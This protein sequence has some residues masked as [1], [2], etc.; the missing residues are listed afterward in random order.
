MLLG[1]LTI[2]ANA[3][4]P[5]PG[6]QQNQGPGPGP[7]GPPEQYRASDGSVWINTDIITIMAN[8]GFPMLHFWYTSDDNGTR[9]KF[10]ISYAAIIEFK[11]LNSDGAF[12][13]DERLYFA[14]LAAYDWTL[15]TG[16]VEDNG[17][18]TEVWLKYTK[19]GVRS[20]GMMPGAPMHGMPDNGS[21]ERFEDVTLQIWAHIYL[22]DYSGNVTDEHGVKVNFT[23]AGGSELK[24][25][26][27]I[28]NFP[29]S[30]ETSGVA[31]QTILRENEAS[32]NHDQ[33]RHR[34]QTR[35]RLRN[36][37]MTSDMNWS[38]GGGNESM[39]ERMNSTDV[40]CIQFVDDVLDVAQGF[41]S[42]VDQ[43]VIT[44]PGGATEAVNVTASY[45]PMGMGLAVYLAYPNFDN[46]TLFHDPSIGLYE[47]GAP[48]ETP[49]I[50]VPV[51]LVIGLLA[52]VAIAA[53]VL[54]RR[55]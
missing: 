9:A 29:F 14:P 44:L 33:F 43:A 23:V 39:F 1:P 4:N 40:Q 53:V 15:T 6:S 13:S 16:A 34:F 45:V 47:S 27:E 32:G 28:G 37:N 51:V 49:P 24:M 50:D 20:G 46:G 21:V 7:G 42:W 31:I 19:G 11:D 8:D 48:T 17:T 12:Q 5:D 22:T 35:E 54:R 26:I 18:T 55:Q 30:S 2:A 36:V 41:F 25:D 10:M 52:A 38:T 3:Q